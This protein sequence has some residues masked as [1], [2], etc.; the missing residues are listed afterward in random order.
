MPLTPVVGRV[1][2][3][4]RPSNS[5]PP[6]QPDNRSL[7][8]RAG[9]A[10]LGGIA[11]VGNI[12]DVPGSMARD[13]IAGAAT[14]NLSRHNPFD[15]LLSPWSSENR[16]TGR[17]LNR[18]AGLAGQQ[19]N[20]ANFAGGLATEIATDPLSLLNFG[21]AATSPLGKVAAKANMIDE[22]GRIASRK[23]NLAQGT[24]LAQK[25]RKA[26]K[27]AEILRGNKIGPR[28][29]QMMVSF[30]ELMQAATPA[31]RQTAEEMA[32]RTGVDIATEGSRP[33][34]GLMGISP[35]PF[36][37]ARWTVGTGP[38]AQKTAAILDD[39]SLNPLAPG[40]RIMDFEIPG[41]GKAPVRAIYNAMDQTLKEATTPFTREVARGLT[42]AKEEARA[43]SRGR[44]AEFANRLVKLGKSTD[45]ESDELRQLFE[46]PQVREN[47][48]PELRQLADDVESELADLLEQS[49]ARGIRLEALDD[50]TLLKYFPRYWADAVAGKKGNQ[51][52]FS[53]FTE[54][55]MMR[56]EF[57]KNIQGG[58]VK[59]KQIL[60]DADLN[61]AID[62]GKSLPFI[63]NLLSTK[64]G[65]DVPDSSI[66]SL[67]SWM[68]NL[69][70]EQ[71]ASGGFANHPLV[72]LQ[73]RLMS[74]RDA[75]ATA[76]KVYE[77]L[78]EPGVLKTTSEPGG[79]KVGDIFSQN[80]FDV[81]NAKE[82]L[83]SKL[84]E[85]AGQ[86]MFSNRSFDNMYVDKPT[87]QWLKSFIDGFSNPK[88]VNE[89]MD[90]FDSLQNVWKWSMIGPWP[91]RYTRDFTSGQMNNVYAGTFSFGSVRDAAR[92]LFG[93]D[94]K[95]A[96]DIPI[97]RRIAK[98]R[99]I[100]NLD[101]KAATELIGELAY[102]YSVLGKY[103]GEAQSVVQQG[104]E[105]L[106]KSSQDIYS[107]L[108]GGGRKQADL[109]RTGKKLVAW[110][111]SGTTYD[112][113]HARLRG[114]LGSNRSTLGVAAAGE[115]VGHMI[116]GFNRLS[117]FI[118]Q[119][120]EGVD[121]AVAAAKVGGAQVQYA[122]RY[123][124]K[125]QRDVLA[126]V[127]PFAKYTMGMTPW[128]LRQLGER[129]GGGMA[130]S[131]KAANRAHDPDE[132][133]PDYV[134]ETAAIPV[135]GT[136]LESL[137]GSPSEPGTNRYLTGFGLSFE[138][139]LS[140][141]GA[142]GVRG[143]LGE[144]ISRMTPPL[145][146]IPEW[147][148]GES[149]FQRGPMGGR[150]LDDMDPLVGRLISNVKQAATGEKQPYPV[151]LPEW[152]EYMMA[153][154]PASRPLSTARTAFDP[155]KSVGSK[156]L[157]L[158]TG[159][160]ISDVSPAS[161][162]ALIADRAETLMRQMGARQFSRTYF[163]EE[164]RQGMTPEELAVAEQLE[165]LQKFVDKSRKSRREE[166]ER[167]SQKK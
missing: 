63:Q 12:L 25:G 40:R 109:L 5:S 155:R 143:A 100:A 115:D 74:G 163:P 88:P 132:L 121:P 120:R 144:T 37:D 158:G 32:K 89:I 83:A 43:Q 79:V 151:R 111:G 4:A 159:L 123:H 108:L 42:K 154:S 138:D 29:A 36:M 125:F 160:R 65:T 2:A 110:P 82:V 78:L 56:E 71:R 102:A 99:G 139:P 14:G 105:S 145:K 131:I 52:V 119:L 57:L 93:Y 147:A 162:E 149:F 81:E 98:E 72:D 51:S 75:I 22:V 86:R 101:D 69:T 96:K 58:T 6:P 128:V 118:K 166:R 28:Q 35:A 61:E 165:A 114:V 9:D 15:Q 148:S 30:D 18:M 10:A 64:Y 140:F 46:L 67:A 92:A 137:I 13:V 8:R 24:S 116:E 50:E 48:T 113:R 3:A 153:N 68:R 23:A 124:T 27:E 152:L 55:S 38:Y 117:P 44:V 146:A 157:N 129:P 26:I 76:D 85:Q 77:V 54:S 62:S 73:A 34:G 20:W 122:N 47:A 150:D 91:A 130:T 66:E 53:T 127:F 133:T 104:G 49:Q 95:G 90:L 60:K 80:R 167:E 107:E 106:G 11:V 70:T 19:D 103:E 45:A 135:Q 97:I 31:Q 39:W 126:R 87:A 33:I 41:T 94:I 156:V 16:A 112:P 7:I 164:T 21:K 141:I 134:A 142:T 1:A 59:L 84:N 161:Q 17:D 136:P